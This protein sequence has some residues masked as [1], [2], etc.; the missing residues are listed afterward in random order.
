MMEAFVVQI[1]FLKLVEDEK[2]FG[3]P[4]DKVLDQKGHHQ[5]CLHAESDVVTSLMA[6]L[7]GFYMEMCQASGTC[8]E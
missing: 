7:A 2:L 6:D 1:K 5:Q 4:L 8:D 3:D